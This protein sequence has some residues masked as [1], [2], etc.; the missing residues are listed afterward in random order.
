MAPRIPVELLGVTRIVFAPCCT[1]F[2]MAAT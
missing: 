1:R 2:S